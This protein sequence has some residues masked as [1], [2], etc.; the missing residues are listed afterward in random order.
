MTDPVKQSLRKRSSV[1]ADRRTARRASPWLVFVPAL[2]LLSFVA[3]AWS[4]ATPISGGP[5]EP[6]H[7]IKAASVARGEFDG[8]SA[9]DGL[10]VV[11]VPAYA[12]Y[13]WAQTCFAYQVNVVPTCAAPLAGDPGKIVA[14]ETSAGR[15]NPTY[16]ALV[17]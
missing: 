7:I 16:Y 1:P 10:Q 5:D 15:Y 4:L 13:T 6:S 14:A 12:A 8:A 9:A 17:G 2:L 11:H 3:A